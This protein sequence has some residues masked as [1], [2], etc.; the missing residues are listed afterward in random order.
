MCQQAYENVL[1]YVTHVG[2]HSNEKGYNL[3]C[4]IRQCPLKFF[5]H[6][7]FRK[8]YE[9]KHKSE[10]EYMYEELSNECTETETT[11]NNI[12]SDTIQISSNRPTYPEDST[13]GDSASEANRPTATVI[14][15]NWSHKGAVFIMNIKEKHR[16]TQVIIVN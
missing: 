4:K 3:V 12:T 5:K 2:L 9:R 1:S 15:D 7:S 14:E 11:A 16:L 6:K 13:P 8:H 10:I